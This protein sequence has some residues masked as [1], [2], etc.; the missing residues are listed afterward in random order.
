[1]AAVACSIQES[2]HK[3]FLSTAL[4]PAR[5]FSG[6]QPSPEA[7]F[8]LASPPQTRQHLPAAAQQHGQQL[9]GRGGSAAGS[10]SPPLDE[11]PRG[12]SVLD[13]PSS[14]RSPQPTVATPSS[15]TQ[16]YAVPPWLQRHFAG[17]PPLPS[18]L[19]S[20]PPG[21]PSLTPEG[22]SGVIS[23]AWRRF[24]AAADAAASRAA[25]VASRRRAAALLAIS[26]HWRGG[27]AR[28]LIRRRRLSAAADAA[29]S[30]AALVASRRLPRV[31]PL[32]AADEGASLDLQ[33][34]SSSMQVVISGEQAQE[35]STRTR[36]RVDGASPLRPAGFRSRRQDGGGQL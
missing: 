19:Y 34:G 11:E 12:R 21:V 14:L 24:L 35:L 10:L 8:H 15:G 23:A 6:D 29:A 9:L 27:L 3:A 1:M 33:Q 30:R 2:S 16:T 17:P 28:S 22:A 7:P 4:S 5:R 31:K 13:A 20:T 18:E 25:L 32:L 36:A 26:R